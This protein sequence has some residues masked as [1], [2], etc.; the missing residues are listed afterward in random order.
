MARGAVDADHLR[1]REPRVDG[2]IGGKT[3]GQAVRVLGIRDQTKP[4]DIL[5][6]RLARLIALQGPQPGERYQLAPFSCVIELRLL[7]MTQPL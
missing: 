3:N 2:L 6:K 4:L 1:T 7:R 5:Q